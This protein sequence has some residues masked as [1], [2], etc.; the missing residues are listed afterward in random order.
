MVIFHPPEVVYVLEWKQKPMWVK[1][2]GK[3]KPEL[4]GRSGDPHLYCVQ[5]FS[6]DDSPRQAEKYWWSEAQ[7]CPGEQVG[8]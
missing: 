3:Q 2:G 5:F 7:P 1:E 6:R 8:G 4:P